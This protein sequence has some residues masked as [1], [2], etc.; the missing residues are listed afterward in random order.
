MVGVL[1][2][3][4]IANRI[5]DHLDAQRIRTLTYLVIGLSGASSLAGAL[6]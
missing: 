2:G 5:V 4:A 1:A 6:L 3:L